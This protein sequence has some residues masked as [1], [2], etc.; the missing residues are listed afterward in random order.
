MP[1]TGFIYNY[2]ISYLTICPKSWPNP[3]HYYMGLFPLSRKNSQGKGKLGSDRQ[4]TLK[5]MNI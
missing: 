4:I 3:G 1:G 2:I 5:I